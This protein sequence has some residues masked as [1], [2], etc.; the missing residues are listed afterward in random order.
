MSWVLSVAQLKP[1]TA[2]YQIAMEHVG[3]CP[4]NTYV[5]GDSQH[6]DLQ[7][8]AELGCK[9]IWAAYGTRINPKNLETILAITPWTA[10]ETS[11][12]FSDPKLKLYAT[13]E[14]F[15]ELRQLIAAP[16]DQFGF[17]L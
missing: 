11:D 15:S 12:F 8:A 2:A 6:K 14:S 5:V 13:L 17:A 4:E 7:P 10:R 16:Q 3:V 9:A 1:S